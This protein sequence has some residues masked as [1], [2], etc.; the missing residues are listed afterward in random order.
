MSRVR[1]LHVQAPLW[2]SGQIAAQIFRDLP[3]LLLLFYMTQ[4]LGISA[5]LAGVAI[6]VP[7][8]F[9]AVLCDG[10]VGVVSDRLRDRF[11]RR[12]FL[13]L[14]AALVPLAMWLLFSGDT[15][16]GSEMGDSEMGRA[17]RISLALALYM[18]V[19]ALFS[20][21]HLAIGTEI[22]RSA[23]ESA[24]VMGWRVA[25][26]A[27][28][29]LLGNSLAP[30]L[31]D[32]WGGDAAAYGQVA[33]LMAGICSAALLL[34]W[35]GAGEAARPA[36]P[37]TATGSALRAVLGNRGLMALF[38]VLML[39]LIGS[40][41][42]YASLAYVFS[43]NLAFAA[44]LATLGIFVLMTAIFAFGAQPLWVMLA[45]RLGKRAGLVIASMGYG[46]SLFA[47][48]CLLPGDE[49]GVYVV[50]AMMGLFNSGCYLNIYALL[51][52]LVEAEA[53][54][55]GTSRAGLYSGLFSAG[56]KIGFAVGGTL[57]TGLVLGAYGFVSG[58]PTQSMTALDGIWTAY[59]V[60]PGCIVMMT[61][62]MAAMMIRPPA[63]VAA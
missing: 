36:Q 10:A 53:Q 30:L 42:A 1:S 54:A 43:Y 17:L 63:V 14:G 31:I 37:R 15:A 46:A 20:V 39:Q 2:A 25:F 61:A 4:L 28:G 21:P 5:A 12:H 33:L 38:A 11:P 49:R 24:L 6:F 16:A 45:R 9:W 55:T 26:S 57:L 13:L 40:G 34:S 44:P 59:A 19:F 41:M 23:D 27:V 47:P 3:S 48:M 18:F 51:A 35:F 56:D 7:K 22:G 8:L 50:G 60:I 29:L 32:R 62:M 58:A 52:D